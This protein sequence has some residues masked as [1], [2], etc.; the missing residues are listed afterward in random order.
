MFDALIEDVSADPWHS[1][2]VVIARAWAT[3]GGAKDLWKEST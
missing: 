1:V 3:C 2:H